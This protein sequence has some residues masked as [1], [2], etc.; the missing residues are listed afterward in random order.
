MLSLG[1]PI[2][3]DPLYPVDRQV[4]VE[5]FDTPLQLLAGELSFQDPVDGG[6]RRF[7]SVRS[8]PL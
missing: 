3:G 1:I 4:P 2:C 7:E 6:A 5:D 8:L